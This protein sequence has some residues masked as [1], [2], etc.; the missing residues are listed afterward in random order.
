MLD[1]RSVTCGAAL[2]LLAACSTPAPRSAPEQSRSS[3][4][5]PLTLADVRWVL[6]TWRGTG[7]GGNPFF[8]EYRVRDDSTFSITYFTDSTR[9]ATQRVTGTVEERAGRIYHTY[10]RSRWVVAEGTPTSLLFHPVEQAD[11]RFRW[12]YVSPTQ[13]TATLMNPDSTG[14][15]VTHTYTLDRLD[16][17]SSSRP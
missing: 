2:A 6:G 13:W 7:G 11:N 14:R 4:A 5:A 17:G 9:T 12:S 1:A 8:E 15:E 3:A 16:A 10:G